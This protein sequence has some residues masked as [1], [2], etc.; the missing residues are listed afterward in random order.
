[1]G[2]VA[3]VAGGGHRHRLVAPSRRGQDAGEVLQPLP[4]C[5]SFGVEHLRGDVVVE[6]VD[7]DA[8]REVTFELGRGSRKHQMAALLRQ[9]TELVQEEGLADSRVA[10]GCETTRRAVPEGVESLAEDSELGRP[11]NPLDR[12]HGQGFRA[13]VPF[14]DSRSSGYGSGSAPEV[15]MP[16]LRQARRMSRFLLQHLHQPHEC[17]VVYAEHPATRATTALRALRGE[18]AVARIAIAAAALHVADDNYL[19]PQ[20]GTS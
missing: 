15:A 11:P 20:P 13:Y 16:G 19:Q 6:C 8:E 14:P 3:V 18:T 10:L 7:E 17:G 4:V 12:A 1:M 9:A 5:R 2:A